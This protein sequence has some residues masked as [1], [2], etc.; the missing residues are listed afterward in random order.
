[1]ATFG[2]Y[3]P[4]SDTNLDTLIDVIMHLKRRSIK[5]P[6]MRFTRVVRDIP[7]NYILGNPVT[8]L[9]QVIDRKALKLGVKCWCIQ[10][11]R[12]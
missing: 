2:K 6:W 3:T 10:D 12:S 1:M 11:E 4:Y 9:R 5:I 7:N 8:N